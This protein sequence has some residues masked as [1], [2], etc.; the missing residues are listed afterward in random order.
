MILCDAGRAVALGSIPVVYAMLGTVPIAQLYLAALIEGTLYV[1]FNIAEVACLPRV[2]PQEQ[3]PAAVGQNQ[4]SE[5]TAVLAGSPLGGALYAASQLLPFLADAISYA[6]SVVSLFFIRTAFQGERTAERRRL[7]V[8]IGAGLRWL[9]NQP[10]IRF[11]AFLTG[12]LN[13]TNGVTLVVIIIAQR[14]GV[15]APVIGLIFA[16]GAIGGVLGSMAGPFFQKR[17]SFGAVIIATVWIQ[18]VAWL[19][20]VFQPQVLLLGVIL[21]VIWVTGPVYNVVQFSYRIALIPDELQGRVNSVF[22]LLAFGFQP[23][24]LALTG[25]LLQWADV[26]PTVLIFGACL[27]GLALATTLN[28]HVRHARPLEEVKAE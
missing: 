3:L 15:S 2:V 19:F 4:A 17:F 26:V 12:G 21:A 16:V 10:L 1:L 23:L 6:A 9:W 27:I 14:Q 5:I 18:A 20:Y 8:E 13:F 28:P 24:G 25:L 22:R 7:R 11:M